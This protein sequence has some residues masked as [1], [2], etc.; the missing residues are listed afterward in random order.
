MKQ[1]TLSEPE[2]SLA[3]KLQ[4]TKSL[5]FLWQRRILQMTW[6]RKKAT[7]TGSNRLRESAANEKA[8]P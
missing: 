1:G 8:I 3:S 7:K 6:R 4:L 5:D 2:Y